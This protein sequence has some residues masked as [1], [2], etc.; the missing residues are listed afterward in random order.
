MG[1]SLLP[2]TSSVYIRDDLSTS[3]HNFY[4]HE[5]STAAT[6]TGFADLSDQSNLRHRVVVTAEEAI[7]YAYN[8]DDTS[9]G[10]YKNAK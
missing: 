5:K 8:T 9:F 7:H 10:F 1:V 2:S 6:A 3:V 4:D